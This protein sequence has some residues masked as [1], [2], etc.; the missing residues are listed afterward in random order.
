VIL[1]AVACRRIGLDGTSGK[2]G[3]RPRRPGATLARAGRVVART[4]LVIASLIA[5][6]SVVPWMI[7]VWLAWHT[8]LVWRGRPAW[9]PLVGCLAILVA[10]MPAWLPGLT[11]LSG[12]M[13][14]A[15]LLQGSWR[16][17]KKTPHPQRLAWGGVLALWLAWA[18][19]SVDWHASARC[20]RRVALDPARPVVCLGDSLT[21][22]MPGAGYP[23]CLDRMIGPPVLNLG[24]P[25]TTAAHTLEIL[26]AVRDLRPQV[27]VVE[28][29]GNDFLRGRDRKAVG[30][31]LEAIILT[32]RE[33]GA[34]VVL[35]EIP[36]G[37]VWDPFGG[38]ERRLAR[39][40]DLELVADTPIRKL[41]FWGPDALGKLFGSNSQLS[42][43]GLHPNARG[44]RLLAEYVRAALVRMYGP[45]VFD[46]AR[47]PARAP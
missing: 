12:V 6:P 22:F 8:W 16:L 32:C 30:A 18:A 23:A 44:D 46:R 17:R 45:E 27:V 42:D 15:G 11:S 47:R 38:L 19:M 9:A 41:V 37:L 5:F 25:G 10:K 40:H 3:G 26:P 39:R 4:A 24:R 1:I 28:L 13:L 35:V 14:A 36:R 20:G 34:E 31:D 29:G 7:A 21:A 43:D 33:F 2:L